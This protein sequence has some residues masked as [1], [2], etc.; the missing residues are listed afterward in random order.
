MNKPLKNDDQISPNPNHTSTIQKMN[1]WN[2]EK[3][4]KCHDGL[5]LIFLPRLQRILEH[6]KYYS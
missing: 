6:L 2:E 3:R 1:V 4:N 5:S